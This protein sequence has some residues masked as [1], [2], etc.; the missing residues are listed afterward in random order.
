MSTTFAPEAA[1]AI[2]QI[3]ARLSQR[4]CAPTQYEQWRATRTAEEVV[5]ECE[6]YESDPAAKYARWITQVL[7]RN[8]VP[9]EWR[10]EL[11]AELMATKRQNDRDQ[12]EWESERR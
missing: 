9:R 3:A 8:R 11:R 5:F 4:T 12:A 7:E 2:A 6:T 10:R 1:E